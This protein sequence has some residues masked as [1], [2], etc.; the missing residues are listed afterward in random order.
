[1]A[2]SSGFPAPITEPS[3]LLRLFLALVILTGSNFHSIL[4]CA[5]DNG[6]LRTPPMGM[7]TWTSVGTAVN[8]DFLLSSAR[9]FITSGMANLGYQY[10]CSDDGWD[11]HRNTS[12]FLQADP[13]KFPSGIPALAQ[14]IH[15]MHLKLGLYGASSSVV[16]SGR[17]GSLYL[18]NID[19]QTY[20]EWGVDYIKQDNCGEYALGMAR[21]QAFAD[22]INRTGTAIAIST[23]PFSIIANPLH[24]QFANLWRT[25]NDIDA[26]YN[27]IV[28]R[29]DLN[30][31]WAAF[32]GPGRWADPDMIQCGNGHLS[33]AE[34]RT[35]FGLWAVAKAPLILGTNVQRLSPSMLAIVMNKG[36]IE[37]NQDPLGVQATKRAANG[38]VSPKYVGMAP[39]AIDSSL[40]GINGV[41]AS[42]LRW[43]LRPLTETASLSLYAPS[44][45][46][47]SMEN[48]FSIYHPATKRCLS[49]RPY[50]H[51]PQPVPV[52]LPCNASDRNQIWLLPR[53]LSVGGLIN[54]ALN[55]SLTAGDST[56]YGTV[57][58]N[59][60]ISLPDSAYGLINMTFTPYQPEP[61]CHSR[62]CDNYVPQQSFYYS[63]RTGTLALALM[64]SNIYRCF[65]GSCYVLTSH[66]PTTADLCLAH[67]ASISNDGV[68]TDIPGVHVWAGPLSNDTY[69]MALDNRNAEDTTT[70]AEFSLLEEDDIGP[71]TSICVRELFSDRSLGV[72][73]GAIT[74][75][76]PTHDTLVLKLFPNSSTC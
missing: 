31:K 69:V 67:V 71:K 23:E 37:V 9:F 42:S 63:P 49:V 7:N 20:A 24:A 48:E 65:E 50:L 5:L 18:E 74:L 61:P 12:G 55:L 14:K 76:V 60:Q 47:I 53:P 73:V 56:V 52:L 64:A 25:G 26:S 10:I 75:T 57:H 30:D 27:T 29:I 34:C 66:Y 39:C 32:T 58:G 13:F 35:N 51:Y 59:D 28:N 68:D 36:V 16:C 62:D 17:P 3:G 54:S 40:P 43:E 45:T 1:M 21:F 44:S 6:L 4:V 38:H 11:T 72:H 22:A 2:P 15:A 8:E 33:E 70:T 19:A 41:R 46:N